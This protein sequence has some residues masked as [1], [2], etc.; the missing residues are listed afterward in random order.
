MSATAGKLIVA[1][2]EMLV[3]ER[4]LPFG[5]RF[6]PKPYSESALVE[7]MI[8]MHAGAN[9]RSVDSSAAGA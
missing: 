6:F 8:D 3:E 2:G 5:A 1:S 4:H 7:A 9:G